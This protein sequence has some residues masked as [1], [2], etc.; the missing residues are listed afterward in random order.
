[1]ITHSRV[2][3]LKTGRPVKEISSATMENSYPPE[4]KSVDELAA[5]IAYALQILKNADI[6]ATGVTTPGGFGNKCKSELSAAMGQALR[7]VFS[8]EIPFYFKYLVDGKEST[9]PVLEHVESL[10]SPNPTLTVNVPASTGDWFGNWDGDQ[11]PTG[12]K[13]ISEDGEEGRMAELIKAGDSAIMFG[14]WAGFYSNGSKKGFAHCKRVITSINKHY[15]DK[16]LWMK[17]SE[18]ARYQAARELTKIEKSQ[19]A[20]ILTAPFAAPAYT[21]R[22]AA[23]TGTPRQATQGG[24]AVALKE[25]RDLRDLRPGHWIRVKEMVTAC[26]NLPKG[27]S[28]LEIQGNL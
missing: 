3:D 24:Q 27:K 4:R 20:I 26:F 6:P 12:D 21:L 7:E 25:V 10:E 28:V 19:T 5:Y 13:Y 14:H 16:T 11:I 23:P 1:M 9:R 15:A 2:I 18:L 22:F 17:S 8:L